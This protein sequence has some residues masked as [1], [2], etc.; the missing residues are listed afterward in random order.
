MRFRGAVIAT[1][2]FEKRGGQP[3]TDVQVV[4]WPLSFPE[5]GDG[6]VRVLECDEVARRTRD[7]RPL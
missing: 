5:A 2:T 4:D 6:Y 7:Q 3:W 1:S